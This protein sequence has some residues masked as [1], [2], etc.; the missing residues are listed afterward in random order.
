MSFERLRV[1]L[2]C[3]G[4]FK[5]EIF[6]YNQDPEISGMT[7][8]PSLMKKAGILDYVSFSKEILKTVTQKPISFEVFADDIPEMTRQAKLIATWGKNVYVK[9][10]ILNTKGISTAP[11]IRELS[12]SGVKV[13]VTAVLTEEQIQESLNVLAGGA[14]SILSIFAGRIA[15]TARDP[16]PLVK[17]AVF[18][19]QKN[20]SAVEVLWASTREVYNLVE[21]ER[22]GCH[23]I[24]VPG[25][26]LEKYREMRM[27]TLQEVSLDTVKTFKKDSDSAG[28]SI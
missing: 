16:N 6:K 2:Y 5:E 22:A 13:N 17:N 14:P 15:D 24:T 9:I 27:K 8:N 20:A 25:S 7:T 19:A 12:H 10:P 18:A 26:I 11:L 21:A 28:F 3:D 1:K 23:I 4:A